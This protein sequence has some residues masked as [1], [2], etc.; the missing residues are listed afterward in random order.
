MRII[1]NFAFTVLNMKEKQLIH[2]LDRE[3][4][5]LTGQVLRLRELQSD[6]TYSYLR[7]VSKLVHCNSSFQIYTY[8][9]IGIFNT[10]N[11]NVSKLWH[12]LSLE[13]RKYNSL[14]SLSYMTTSLLICVLLENS[15][16]EFYRSVRCEHWKKL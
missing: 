4:T 3:P 8:T 10:A 1:H 2:L 12:N 7:L 6:S 16:S 13:W 15:F 5:V 11:V 14:R 9:F